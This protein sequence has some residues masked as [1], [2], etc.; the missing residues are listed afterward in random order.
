ML[1]M[2]SKPSGDVFNPVFGP[3]VSL[4][5]FGRLQTLTNN[6]TGLQSTTG[7]QNALYDV[8]TVSRRV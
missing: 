8:Q 1:Y 6:R 2:T 5:R 4:V 3:V 7:L